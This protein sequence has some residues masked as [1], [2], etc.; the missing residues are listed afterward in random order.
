MTG[1]M[2]VGV[3]RTHQRCNHEPIIQPQSS[4]KPFVPD[5]YPQGHRHTRNRQ[6]DIGDGRDNITRSH[7]SA[8]DDR[9]SENHGRQPILFNSVRTDLRHKPLEGTDVS[10]RPGLGEPL[11]PTPA[12][13]N[14][15]Y[16]V[17]HLLASSRVAFPTQLPQQ[18]R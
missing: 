16:T 4:V 17:P 18:H 12:S 2:I 14:K 7:G 3:E 13:S 1:C 15:L 10:Q 8:G 6:T 5:Y 11:V 9:R